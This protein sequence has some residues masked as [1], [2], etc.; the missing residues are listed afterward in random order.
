MKSPNVVLAL[1]LAGALLAPVCLAATNANGLPIYDPLSGYQDPRSGYIDPRSGYD[2]RAG[3]ADPRSGYPDPRNSIPDPRSGYPDP[4]KGYPDPRFAYPDPRLGYPDPRKGYPDPR[5]PS[6]YPNGYTMLLGNGAVYF[7]V[8]Q[9]QDRLYC[10]ESRAFYPTVRFCRAPWLRLLRG[11]GVVTVP[12][13][14]LPGRP[15][16]SNR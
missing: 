5:G 9:N 1:A 13:A 2:P 7:D 16:Q 3:Y 8:P 11:A 14:T 10:P 12:P 15:A 4:R 6:A